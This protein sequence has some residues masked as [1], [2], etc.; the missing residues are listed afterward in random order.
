[1]ADVPGVHD[2]EALRQLVPARPLVVVRLRHDA[3]G[4]TPVRNHADALG[5]D[6][7]RGDALLHRLADHDHAVGGAQRRVDQHA[8]EADDDR[9]AEP[10]ELDCDLGEDVLHHHE[11]RRSEARGDETRRSSRRTAGRSCRR[12]GRA[13]GRASPSRPPRARTRG[14]SSPGP[15]GARGR[16]RSSG[17]ARSSRRCAP[18]GG[19]GRGTRR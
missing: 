15:G 7:L 2:D 4:V 8:Q 3:R 1:M 18:G 6:A 10:S 13:G 19:A 5:R 11:Q 14:S 17:R 9:V 16:R 12:R